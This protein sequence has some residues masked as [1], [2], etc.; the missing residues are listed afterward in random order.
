MSWLYE[1]PYPVDLG[2]VGASVRRALENA[3]ARLGA[4]RQPG[5]GEVSGLSSANR[6]PRPTAEGLY[7]LWKPGA[8]PELFGFWLVFGNAYLD[9]G[10]DGPPDTA[11]P[12][13][14]GLLTALTE[15]VW[16]EY[17][18]PVRPARWSPVVV[19]E[20]PHTLAARATLAPP[21]VVSAEQGSALE[22]SAGNWLPLGGGAADAA[23]A[24][25]RGGKDPWSHLPA[26]RSILTVVRCTL[27]KEG[28]LARG[29]WTLV[30][31]Y[32]LA[33]E[34]PA[35]GRPVG[36]AQWLAA[37]QAAVPT[38]PLPSI[39]DPD[40]V[41]RHALGPPLALPEDRVGFPSSAWLTR[42]LASWPST[43][44]DLT[45][46]AL[47]DRDVGARWKA[48]VK[49][50]LASTLGVMSVTLGVALVV[51]A[52]SRP[53][54]GDAEKPTP[55]QPQP[56]LSVCSPSDAQFINE[57][58]CQVDALSGTGDAS[59]THCADR[60]SIA[61][62]PATPGDLQAAWCGLRDRDAD[63]WVATISSG[64]KKKEV[65][66]ADLAAARA[67]FNVLG[68]PYRYGFN[69]D[70][71][72]GPGATRVADPEL[73]LLDESLK[74]QGLVSVV[75]ELDQT[76]DQ[77]RPWLLRQTQGAILA[78]H[79]GEP[80]LI[81]RPAVDGPSALRSLVSGAAMEGLAQSESSCFQHGMSYGI[82][83]SW[84]QDGLGVRPPQRYTELCRRSVSPISMPDGAEAAV[85][86]SAADD[87][88][89]TRVAWAKIGGPADPAQAPLV[90]RYMASRFAGG[91]AI[92][93]EG[94]GPT[95]A[96]HAAL[97]AGE[98][99]PVLGALGLWEVPVGVPQ[100][101]NV[102]RGAVGQQLA[103]DAALGF[104]D[105]DSN[106]LGACWRI[107]KDLTLTYPRVHPLL[108]PPEQPWPSVEQQ[109]CGQ[110]CAAAYHLRPLPEGATWVTPLEDLRLCL[111]GGPPRL[112]EGNR[113]LDRLQLPW[114]PAKDGG[115]KPA[116][117]SELCAFHV[118]AQGYLPPPVVVGEIPSQLWAGTGTR[119]S[120]LAGGPDGTAQKSAL[121]LS[122]V[123]KARSINSCG[124][125]A[126]QCMVAGM[127]DVM[128]QD[129]YRAYEWS[130]AWNRDVLALVNPDSRGGDGRV[131]VMNDSPWCGLIQ[132]FVSRDGRLPEGQLDYPCAFGVE[133]TRTAI[134]NSIRTISAG[135]VAETAP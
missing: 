36:L 44:A 67:C 7:L 72:A 70:P 81:S 28:N 82:T 33:A 121:A 38:S 34:G 8:P 53:A 111:D 21:G 108:G 101:Y 129:R 120:Q 124:H 68:K 15:A 5:G 110:A 134:Y 89:A 1:G 75:A 63:V 52:L 2:A 69:L 96:C 94:D 65:P 133:E 135:R 100:S 3:E 6:G 87:L 61:E 114:N 46:G 128:G 91:R 78:T 93:K 122:S 116:R 58:R 41:A 45:H 103:F 30:D 35:S 90:E 73:L 131:S 102:R 126:A 13:V 9:Q 112:D 12:Y 39:Q 115:W 37:A 76:C 59:R 86:G 23:G 25:A 42:G 132:P 83:E 51:Y 92:P 47:R 62:V 4:A 60:A 85:G 88:E 55:P 57:L 16:W 22:I 31:P 54:E 119:N 27:E 17:L 24:A 40:R 10:V 64:D 118:I 113:R 48:Q 71:S 105:A 43:P 56:A 80:A 104:L 99:E 74:I 66:W 109:V 77:L 11:P 26:E 79:V 49:Q 117:A 32:A 20:W 130:T 97:V 127:L 106:G 19:L 107:V 50:V 84:Q 95:W 98:G 125:V 29:R 123:G 14:D 18:V